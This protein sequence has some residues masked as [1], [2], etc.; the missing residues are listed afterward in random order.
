MAKRK[1]KRSQTQY[2]LFDLT[3]DEAELCSGVEEVKALVQFKLEDGL[4]IDDLELYTLGEK[5]NLSLE[6][7]VL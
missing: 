1:K 3:S 2:V 7:K 6:I 5:K 4:N